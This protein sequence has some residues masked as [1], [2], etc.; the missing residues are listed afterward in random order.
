VEPLNVPYSGRF[1]FTRVVTLI[2]LASRQRALNFLSGSK[3]D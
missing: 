3:S 2:V 1:G